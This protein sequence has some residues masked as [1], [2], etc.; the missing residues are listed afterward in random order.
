MNKKEFMLR[1]EAL[2]DGI[3]EEEKKEALAFY[4]SYFEDAGEENE[5]KI[6]RE[7][8]SP[9]QVADTIRANLGLGEAAETAEKTGKAA[10]RQETA[11]NANPTAGSMGAGSNQTGSVGAGPNQAGS[12]GEGPDQGAS[13]GTGYNPGGSMGAGYGP[14]DG[15][16][17]YGGQDPQPGYGNAYGNGAGQNTVP[18]RRDSTR[19]VLIVLLII[20]T[21]PIWIGALGGILGGVCGLFFGLLG[22]TLGCLI[23]G[24][25]AFGI[26]ISLCAGGMASVGLIT[27]GAAL[28]VF[29]LGLAA[30]VLFVLI[31]GKFIPWLVRGIVSLVQ[32]LLYGKKEVPGV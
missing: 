20:L 1:L 19:T 14:G 11:G 15:N 27:M 13:M 12:M 3:P 4:V 28:L 9:E 31:C 5:E 17:A 30:L 24:A 21:S 26:G 18:P 32:R 23:G 29:A 7:L 2:L 16:A 25:A 8:E 6:L 22:I 10:S